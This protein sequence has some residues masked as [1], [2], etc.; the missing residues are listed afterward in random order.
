MRGCGEAWYEARLLSSNRAQSHEDPKAQLCKCP[1]ESTRKET[2][3]M[4]IEC[5]SPKK[6]QPSLG[7]YYLQTVKEVVC[8]LIEKWGLGE[9]KHYVRA[10]TQAVCCV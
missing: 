3:P 7:G 9:I 6:E 2:G 5:G 4:S 10:P 8:L 1:G